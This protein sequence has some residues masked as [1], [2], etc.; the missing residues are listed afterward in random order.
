M[1][2]FEALV[3]VTHLETWS[4]KAEDVIEAREK[5]NAL[6]ADVETQDDGGEV[7]DWEIT[8]IKQSAS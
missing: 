4:V 1:P 8:T 6:H 5:I 3:R 7:I 2:E